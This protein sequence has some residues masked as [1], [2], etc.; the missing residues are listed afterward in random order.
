MFEFWESD[1]QGHSAREQTTSHDLPPGNLMKR[2]RGLNRFSRMARGLKL[3]NSNTTGAES[4]PGAAIEPE[5]L[6][7]RHLRAYAPV[8]DRTLRSWIH[9]PVDPLPAVRV[10]GKIFVRKSVFD[11][12]LEHHTIRSLASADI[13]DIAR[14]VLERKSD[15]R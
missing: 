9:D 3:K 4:A 5:W 14:D 1:S 13:D 8:S 10:N 2:R 6:D 7:L 11:D 12:W 15:G